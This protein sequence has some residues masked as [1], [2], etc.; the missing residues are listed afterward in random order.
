MCGRVLLYVGV[1]IAFKLTLLLRV[2]LLR[3]WK[4][5][6]ICGCVGRQIKGNDSIEQMEKTI[7]EKL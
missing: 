6:D 7:R 5:T 2:A 1:W 4:G 3:V